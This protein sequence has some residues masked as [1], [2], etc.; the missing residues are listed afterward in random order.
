MRV[1]ARTVLP[2]AAIGGLAALSVA[3]PAASVQVPAA[4]AAALAATIHVHPMVLSRFV[5]KTQPPTEAQCIS[6]YGI[7]CYDPAQIQTAYNEQ[8]LFHVRHRRPPDAAARGPHPTAPACL[9]YVTG[10]A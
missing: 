1:S 10:C 9:R 3:V 4:G 8:P 7:P 2:V 6:A 5:S